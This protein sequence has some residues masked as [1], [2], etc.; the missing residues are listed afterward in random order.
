MRCFCCNAP[1][2]FLDKKTGRDYCNRCFSSQA[3]CLLEYDFGDDYIYEPD[4]NGT[5]ITK[6][7]LEN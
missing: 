1:A 3:S 4:D 2:D 5:D 7:N 6:L